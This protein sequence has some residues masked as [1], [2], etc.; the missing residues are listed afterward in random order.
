MPHGEA[1]RAV[2]EALRLPLPAFRNLCDRL[3]P[4]LERSPQS[5]MIRG[6]ILTVEHITAAV[7][8]RLAHG[9][10]VHAVSH[11]FGIAESTLSLLTREVCNAIV[12]VLMPEVICLPA[13]ERVREVC[14]L[15]RLR[16]G[17]P[18]CFGAVDGTHIQLSVRP[19]Q[20]RAP[21]DYYCSR[22]DMYSIVMQAVVDS[23]GMFMDIDVRWPGRVHDAHIFRESNFFRVFP[24]AYPGMEQVINGVRVPLYVVADSAYPLAP[25]CMKRYVAGPHEGPTRVF[26]AALQSARIVVENAFSRLKGRW[27][28]LRSLNVN[29]AYAATVVAACA[30][31]H[32]YCEAA[33]PGDMVD[34]E[35]E[36]VED[37]VEQA[38]V[39][40]GGA[41][42]DALYQYVAAGQAGP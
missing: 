4:V 32:N 18:N 27:R 41:V 39:Q 29:V 8:Y 19:P 16:S 10:V 35:P 15:F 7:L 22:K 30:V 28:I 31:L 26:D 42:R 17:L 36:P 33:D 2:R 11:M 3:R 20:S 23:R 6:E 13:A 1:D 40:G 9:G 37:A 34:V 12:V 25:W 14:H 38:H 24:T 5:F 21:G